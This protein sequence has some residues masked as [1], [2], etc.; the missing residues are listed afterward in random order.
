MYIITNIVDGCAVSI[1]RAETATFSFH[2]SRPED[3]HSSILLELACPC[4]SL[5]PVLSAEL[6][7]VT[8]KMPIIVTIVQLLTNTHRFRL[9]RLTRHPNC[10]TVSPKRVSKR[11]SVPSHTR[12]TAVTRFCVLSCQNWITVQSPETD[13]RVP[14]SHHCSVSLSSVT[15]SIGKRCSSVVGFTHPVP[16]YL[17]MLYN[18]PYT[19]FV[20]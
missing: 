13:Y 9:T 18:I 15:G 5:I 20:I 3:G 17:S 7:G 12:Q 6:H 11:L 2:P 1:F 16:L 4:K 8:S 10:S 14:K 19:A